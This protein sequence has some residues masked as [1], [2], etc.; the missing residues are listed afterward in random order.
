MSHTDG[1]GTSSAVFKSK[2]PQ[3]SYG[4]SVSVGTQTSALHPTIALGTIKEFRRR[5]ACRVSD[6]RKYFKASLGTSCA[7]LWRNLCVRIQVTTNYPVRITESALKPYRLNGSSS[8]AFLDAPRRCDA[9]AR[10]LYVHSIGQAY[11]K[12]I[13]RPQSS[14][15][16]WLGAGFTSLAANLG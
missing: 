1:N 11:D 13:L 10:I 14:F 3:Q 8:F 9:L 7:N 16:L 2:W 6:A 15:H 4:I 12:C 5:R